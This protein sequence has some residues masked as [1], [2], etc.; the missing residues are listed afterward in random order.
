MDIPLLF[1]FSISSSAS[2]KSLS[3]SFIE[4][5]MVGPIPLSSYIRGE[6]SKIDG[7]KEKTQVISCF[8][9][10]QDWNICQCNQ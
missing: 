10:F 7:E 8:S 2:L 4:Q 6:A 9:E 5:T 3:F 1:S